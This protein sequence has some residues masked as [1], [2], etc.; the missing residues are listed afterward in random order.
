MKKLLF[1]ACIALSLAFVSCDK[2]KDCSCT[3]TTSSPEMLEAS[4]TTSFVTIKSG[5]CDDLN[6][7][8]S[9]NQ[10]GFEGEEIT[11]TQ[12]SVCSEVK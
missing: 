1:L 3:V 12:K 10:P 9:T 4:T 11:V 2:S 6:A 8:H 7:D 5:K